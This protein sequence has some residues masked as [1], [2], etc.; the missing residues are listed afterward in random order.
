MLYDDIQ[1]W[2]TKLKTWS[3]I[4][5]YIQHNLK[6]QYFKDDPLFPHMLK[7][8]LGI[9]KNEYVTKWLSRVYRH[10]FKAYAL[11]NNA[12]YQASYLILGNAGY[13]FDRMHN[14]FHTNLLKLNNICLTNDNSLCNHTISTIFVYKLSDTYYYTHLGYETFSTLYVGDHID[15]EIN[16][17][18]RLNSYTKPMIFGSVGLKECLSGV[19]D[20]NT[21]NTLWVF[22]KSN[23]FN[24]NC[25]VEA[26]NKP[27]TNQWFAAVLKQPVESVLSEI[28][29][30]QLDIPL[31][32]I[33]V[34]INMQGADNITDIL[35]I[36]KQQS[37]ESNVYPDTCSQ[38]E[39]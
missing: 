34:L 36:L 20:F 24:F 12:D 18:D 9:N 10:V 39:F 1:N 7:M 37:N 15:Y 27:D 4:P 23:K 38:I 2:L 32:T 16:G 28:L 21:A 3:V 13:S 29:A 19:V 31:Q 8:A 30:Y 26:F 33:S 22:L 6:K 17:L 25:L 35:N 5:G 11:N 14:R